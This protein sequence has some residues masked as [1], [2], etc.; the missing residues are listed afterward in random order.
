LH[1][2]HEGL[3]TLCTYI[4]NLTS[5]QRLA[6][7]HLLMVHFGVEMSTTLM[8]IGNKMR[9]IQM[10][11]YVLWLLLEHSYYV[12][13]NRFTGWDMK[14]EKEDLMY[15]KIHLDWGVLQLGNQKAF[16]Y[17]ICANDFVYTPFQWIALLNQINHPR[18]QPWLNHH[19]DLFFSQTTLDYAKK[20]NAWLEFFQ[21][22]DNFMPMYMALRSPNNMPIRDAEAL[23][24]HVRSQ[25]V[26]LLSSPL[27]FQWCS[28][29]EPLLNSLQ[30]PWLRDVLHEA[31]A[32]SIQSSALHA[33]LSDALQLPLQTMLPISR[34]VAQWLDGDQA[35]RPHLTHLQQQIQNQEIF[36]ALARR[37][38][39]FSTNSTTV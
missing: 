24:E 13:T 27:P 18:G 33:T 25:L 4:A 37:A 10:C 21:I 2:T 29:F 16:F 15:L 3:L 14:P 8:Q 31:H 11:R 6:V 23:N 19:F 39:E 30:T 28:E 34:E 20:H 35:M 1:N 36:A 26:R 17:G 12:Y 9:F 22:A 32:R 38:A 7:L 5:A